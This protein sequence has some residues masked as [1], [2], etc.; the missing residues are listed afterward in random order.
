[1]C[2]ASSLGN[3]DTRAA[4]CHPMAEYG[5]LSS[6]HFSVRLLYS[7]CVPPRDSLCSLKT[8]EKE[9][10]NLARHFPIGFL[11][12]VGRLWPLK[13]HWSK[14]EERKKMKILYRSASWTLFPRCTP[15]VY[16]R[17]FAAGQWNK[18]L[19]IIVFCWCDECRCFVLSCPCQPPVS[20]FASCLLLFP[21][22]AR[23]FIMKVNTVGE[24]GRGGGRKKKKSTKVCFS[25][26]SHG[27]DSS[28][29]LT[30]GWKSS[31]S[32]SGACLSLMI[33]TWHPPSLLYLCFPAL[34]WV[35]LELL[36][37]VSLWDSFKHPSPLLWTS[38]RNWPAFVSDLNRW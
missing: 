21:S 28:A 11:A 23:I 24:R 6:P 1:M 8:K 35:S 4:S 34:S 18:F 12:S 26:S 32:W 15:A 3:H 31:R 20:S 38:Y 29:L 37:S 2:E 36:P 13:S 9:C 30:C 33:S 17:W 10:V 5:I 25:H 22:K 14:K 7:V 19:R 27:C 16:G